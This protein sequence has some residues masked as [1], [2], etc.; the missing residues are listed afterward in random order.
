M[1]HA[2][3]GAIP[4]GRSTETGLV[5]PSLR[6]VA[7]MNE[8]QGNGYQDHVNG[9]AHYFLFV[10]AGDPGRALSAITRLSQETDPRS[11]RAP[12]GLPGTQSQIWNCTGGA[13]Q[14]WNLP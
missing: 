4:A 9:R 5:G 3:N 8:R 7:F 10:Y 6:Y 12:A 11:R 14:A 13:N 1:D 2:R